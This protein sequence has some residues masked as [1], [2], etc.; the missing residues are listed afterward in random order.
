MEEEG[1][2]DSYEYGKK[3]PTDFIRLKKANYD[4]RRL[5]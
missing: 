1:G 5:S 4:C 3:I 2:L